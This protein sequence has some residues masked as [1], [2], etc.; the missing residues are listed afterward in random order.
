MRKA[1]LSIL[2]LTQGI[3][4]IMGANIGTTLTGWIIAGIGVAKFSIATLAVPI[5][6][7]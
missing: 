6:G 5:F 3:G 1:K 2:A 4:V 7:A